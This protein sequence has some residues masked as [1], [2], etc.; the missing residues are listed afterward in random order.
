LWP[1]AYCG[2]E[3]DETSTVCEN[4]GALMDEIGD[5][6]DNKDSEDLF[7]DDEGL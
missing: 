2:H 6:G 4:C 5:S 7:F 3:N 1:C